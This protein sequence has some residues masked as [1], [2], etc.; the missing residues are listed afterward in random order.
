MDYTAR[1]VGHESN[2]AH[3]QGVN[4][5]FLSTLNHKPLPVLL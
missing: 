1:L 4:E 5:S 2:T 3:A